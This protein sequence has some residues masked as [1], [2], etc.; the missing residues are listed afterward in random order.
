MSHIVFI[1]LGVVSFVFFVST[2]IR[3]LLLSAGLPQNRFLRNSIQFLIMFLYNSKSP[4][5]HVTSHSKA[6]EKLRGRNPYHFY[7]IG[8]W[9]P[10]V[11]WLVSAS[12]ASLF[13]LTGYWKAGKHISLGRDN[14][15]VL[16]TFFNENTRPTSLIDCCIDW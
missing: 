9:A 1:P 12:C 11:I 5:N 10:A 6:Q 7:L 8:Y 13:T 14:S 4:S 15:S 2:K 16:S 3:M